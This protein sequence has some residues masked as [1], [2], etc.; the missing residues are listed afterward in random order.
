MKRFAFL[1]IALLLS[2]MALAQPEMQPRRVLVASPQ[3]PQAWYAMW[4]GSNREDYEWDAYPTYEAYKNMMQAFAEEHPDRCTAMELGTLKSGRQLLFC[5]INNGR[6]DGKPKFL[7]TST[8]H[9]DELTGMMLML[10]F[11][12][13]LCTSEDPRILNLV[14]NLDIFIS[15]NTNPD[16]TYHGGNHTVSGARRRNA[17]DVDL[18]RNYP[19]FDDGPHP[20]GYAYQDETIWMMDLAR[21]YPFT[22]AANFHTGSEVVN[23]PWDTYQPLHPDDDWWRLVCHEYAENVHL[24]DTTYM[25]AYDNGIVNGYVWYSI[26]GSR[27]DYMNYY[28]ECREVTIEC[29]NAYTP[30][31]SL[32][33]MYWNYNHESIIRYMEQ[34]LNGIHGTVTDS[35]TGK[36]LE[37]KVVIEG[38]DHH[39]S[40]VSSHLPAGD[41]H[42]PIKGGTYEVTYSCRGYNP[43]TLTVTVADGETVVQD[44][45]L[46]STTAGVDEY[47]DALTGEYYIVNLLGQTLKSGVL[48]GQQ[49][50]VSSLPN[51]IYILKT[52]KTTRKVVVRH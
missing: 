4:D 12:D 9:G 39:G 41:Y 7:Y 10:R 40:S 29:S 8:M 11:I 2:G 15:P 14:D 26:W 24:Q 28:A 48:D 45:Q 13:E 30:D 34:C 6:P 18:N 32:M 44:V 51:G 50:D 49:P 46:V 25:I 36:P 20:D 47:Q 31:P 42:R 3:A 23:Y 22:M 52:G 1:L 38:H 16:G 5:R 27:Q 43:Q 19:D 17:N 33:P 21:E 37:A 35:L